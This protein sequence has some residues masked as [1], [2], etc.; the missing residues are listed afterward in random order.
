[1]AV[2]PAKKV[3][4]VDDEPDAAEFVKTMLEAQDYEVCTAG[5]GVEGLRKA[6]REKP[7][8]VILDIQMPGKDGFSTFAEMREDPDLSGIPVIVLTGVGE[9]TGMRFSAE[10]MERFMG[11]RPEGYLEKPVDPADLQEKVAEVV[12]R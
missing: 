8:L 1:M 4:V 2:K 10:Q 12:G 6:R 11:S 3:L 7:D 5:D 9:R